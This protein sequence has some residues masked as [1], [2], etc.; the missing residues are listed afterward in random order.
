MFDKNS[1]SSGA[2]TNFRGKP[3][4]DYDYQKLNDFFEL[5]PPILPRLLD[6]ERRLAGTNFFSKMDHCVGF[7]NLRMHPNLIEST[8]FYFRGLGTYV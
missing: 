4:V 5:L 3:R 1:D 7:H 2:S 8:T 6:I